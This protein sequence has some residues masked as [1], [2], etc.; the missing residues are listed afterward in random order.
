ALS[1]AK[2]GETIVMKSGDYGSLDIS[3]K[4]FS[5]YVTL[6]SEE[7]LGAVFDQVKIRDTD[8]LRIDNVH[9]DN[10]SN[11]SSASSIVSVTEGS[12][13]VQFLNSEVNGKVDGTYT[14]HY[15]LYT[16]DVTDVTF[17]GNY[18]HDVK[19]GGTFY[20]AE[21]LTVSGNT[22]D[23]TGS[24][25][26]KF[27][28]VHGVLIEGNMGARHIY[29]EAGSHLDFIQFQGN[30]SSDIV[31]R[32]NVSL[33]GTRGDVQGIFMDDA[34]YTNVL[35][36]QNVIVTGMIHG[37][38]LTSGTNVVAR[39][40]T[41][42]NLSD[43]GSKATKVMVDGQSYDNIQTSYLQDASSGTNLTLQNV[44]SNGPLYYGDFFVN[45]EAGRWITLED[46]VAIDGMIP[47][48]MGATGTI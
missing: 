24:D 23:Y 27:I 18:V 1:S 45:P 14:G 12:N 22:I 33:P 29:P 9:V 36:E 10:P 43:E 35:I 41:V 44:D 47:D 13:H 2:G 3:G 16:K 5:S 38:T 25:S 32:G 37:V 48:N 21:D 39:N 28:S 15:G 46:L 6:V 17:S 31:I 11:G 30:D 20:N 8:Y 26:L 40:N 34:H 4:S 7:P 42:I 19:I